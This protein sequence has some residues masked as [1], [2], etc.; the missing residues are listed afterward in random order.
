MHE[1]GGLCDRV[2]IIAGG[3]IVADG[4]VADI[5][6]LAGTQT[7]EDAFIHLSQLAEGDAHNV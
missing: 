6:A 5:I 4:S 2:L 3:K 7:L 1:V